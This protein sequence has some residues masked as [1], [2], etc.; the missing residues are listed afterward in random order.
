MERDEL[1]VADYEYKR[2]VTAFLAEGG[3]DTL[4]AVADE[5][6]KFNRNFPTLIQEMASLRGSIDRMPR[7]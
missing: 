3:H 5:L 7:R 4:K 1:I 2:A 6:A